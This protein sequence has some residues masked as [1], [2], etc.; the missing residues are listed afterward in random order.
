MPRPISLG[1]PALLREQAQSLCHGYRHLG[2]DRHAATFLKELLFSILRSHLARIAL[3]KT[4]AGRIPNSY[5]YPAIHHTAQLGLRALFCQIP[6]PH[7]SW[8]Y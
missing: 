6:V 5:T 2:Q 4:A 8:D 1:A 3:H 7:T